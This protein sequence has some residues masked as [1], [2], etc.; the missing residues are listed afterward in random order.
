[1]GKKYK[2]ISN[3]TRLK[4]INLIHNQSM[5]IS[6]AAQACGVYDPTA[7]AINKVYLT[8]N[9]VDKKSHRLR[10]TKACNRPH[11]TSRCNEA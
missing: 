6:K 10:R 3:E 11:C 1:M 2:P 9:R 5:S 4:L 8:E 7:K